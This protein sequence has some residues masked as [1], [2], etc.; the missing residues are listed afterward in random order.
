MDSP[1]EIKA[2]QRVEREKRERWVLGGWSCQMS[3]KMR[4][5]RRAER[6]RSSG[7]VAR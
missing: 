3:F 1:N 4:S 5:S 2:H 6:E 7:G